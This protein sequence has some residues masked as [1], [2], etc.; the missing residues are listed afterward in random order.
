MGPMT[1]NQRHGTDDFAKI[2]E[3]QTSPSPIIFIK[4]ITVEC[5]LYQNYYR[6]TNFS[7]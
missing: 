5:L 6:I 2:L 7:N 1:Q 4:K 3:F